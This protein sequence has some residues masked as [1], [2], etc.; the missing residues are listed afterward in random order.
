MPSS[1]S[2]KNAR[3]RSGRQKLF[4]F[5]SKGS[6]GKYQKHRAEKLTKNLFELVRGALEGSSQEAS[7]S[8]QLFLVRMRVSHKSE[9]DIRYTGTVI[10]VVPDFSS[11]Y[12]VKYDD[13][14]AIYSYQLLGDYRNGD[15]E[16]MT[17]EWLN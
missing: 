1:S 10:S 11:W 15:L 13:D 14:T 12:N 3:T 17:K 6:S 7:T 16:I 4:L 2:A 5:S 9:G 8:S